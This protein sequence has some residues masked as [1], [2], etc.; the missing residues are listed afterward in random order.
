MINDDNLRA[1]QE[2]AG[3]RPNPSPVSRGIST[4][5]ARRGT[6]EFD[7]LMDELLD[8][9]DLEDE[10]LDEIV[11]VRRAGDSFEIRLKGEKQWELLEEDGDDDD[12]V[13]GRD[14]DFGDGEE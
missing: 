13:A 8:E 5:Q 10:E 6:P 14:E 11:E 9:W 3:T 12:E 2:A 7:D 4:D 1:R